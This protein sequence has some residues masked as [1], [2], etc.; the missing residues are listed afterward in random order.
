VLNTTFGFLVIFSVLAL[1]FHLL[2][3]IPK[4]RTRRFW[5]LAESLGLLCVGVGLLIALGEFRTRTQRKDLQELDAYMQFHIRYARSRAEEMVSYCRR[6]MNTSGRIGSAS[7]SEFDEAER[8]A[9]SAV[10]AVRPSYESYQ[11]RRFFQEHSN[12]KANEDA[13]VQQLK[14]SV[15]TL[16][17]EMDQG[18]RNM[19][20]L[21]K[22]LKRRGQLLWLAPLPPW[23]LA[24]GFALLITKVSADW[25]MGPGLHK[26]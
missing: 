19:Q 12:V 8:W 7:S 18:D 23:L 16:L 22:G 26:S 5:L 2:L 1:L 13:I 20:H 24:F 3:L 17:M 14:F 21:L 11:W 6:L 25:T 4:A 9:I 15:L 10:E